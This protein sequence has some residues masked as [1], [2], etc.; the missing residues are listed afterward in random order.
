MLP[1]KPDEHLV[2]QLFR[3]AAALGH[4]HPTKAPVSSS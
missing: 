3:K 1:Q 2:S 4:I